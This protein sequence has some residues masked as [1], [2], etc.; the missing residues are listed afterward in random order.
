MSK[1][2][3]NDYNFF[4]K[5]WLLPADYSDFRLE[6]EKREQNNDSKCYIV[7]PEA[8][9]QGRGIFLTFKTDCV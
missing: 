9:C 2:F 4:P 7:K 6:V 5:T 3:P 1:K 8:D